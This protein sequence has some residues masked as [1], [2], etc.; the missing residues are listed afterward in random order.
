MTLNTDVYAVGEGAGVVMLVESL[1]LIRQL[2]SSC[3]AVPAEGIPQLVSGIVTGHAAFHGCAVFLAGDLQSPSGGIQPLTVASSPHSFVEEISLPKV[4]DVIQTGGAYRWPGAR[5]RAGKSQSGLLIQSISVGG[6]A[7]GAI[8]VH[9][10]DPRVFQVW[11]ENLLGLIA[12]ILG[13]ALCRCDVGQPALTG[14]SEETPVEHVMPQ[15]GEFADMPVDLDALTGLATPET[16]QRC[17]EKSRELTGPMP[18]L[19]FLDIDRFRMIRECGGTTLSDHV[20]EVLSGVLL[21]LAGRDCA[22]SRIG[23]DQFGMI[24]RLAGREQAL[25]KATMLLESVEALR[26]SHDGERYELTASVGIVRPNRYQ[27][28]PEESIRKARD[29]CREAK[30]LGGGHVQFYQDQLVATARLEEDG[31]ILNQLIRAFKD[32]DLLLYAQEIQPLEQPK[33]P[34]A[35]RFEILLR[36]QGHKGSIYSAGMFLPVAERYGLSAKLDR[37]VVGEALR[38]LS[39]LP[40]EL[41]ANRSFAINLS[42]HSVDSACFLDFVLDA[43]A[44]TGLPP[45]HVCFEITETAAISDIQAARAFVDALQAIGCEFALDD[46][47]SGHTSFLYLRDLPVDYLKI[48]GNLVRDIAN[49]AFSRSIVRSIHDIAKTMGKCTIAEYIETDSILNTVKEIGIDFGQGYTLA[50][51]K[52]LMEAI[53]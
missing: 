39:E 33:N 42:G 52:P 5:E 50:V 53:G 49:D 46:F 48:D 9:H 15:T 17:L 24:M 4:V 2:A 43:F 51:P 27:D 3:V 11:H 41:L 10:P 35:S 12:D 32:N 6:R 45:Q 7:V 37:W 31:R 18:Y 1:S 30:H 14:P 29:A 40:R 21:R 23:V 19:F 36:A 13:L 34:A 8:A 20:I 44:V 16:F 47:G 38:Q 22:V 25:E 28:T 26:F